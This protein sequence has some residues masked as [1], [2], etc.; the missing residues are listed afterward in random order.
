MKLRKDIDEMLKDPDRHDWDW[1]S[2]NCDLTKEQIDKAKDHLSWYW[3]TLH[4]SFSEEE[5]RK[6]L[7][8][9]EW[10]WITFRGDITESFL[11]EIADYIPQWKALDNLT[12]S[13][14]FKREINSE[15]NPVID[16]TNILRVDR[17]LCNL[18]YDEMSEFISKKDWDYISEKVWLSTDSIKRCSKYINW[19]L[20]SQHIEFPYDFYWEFRKK[21]DWTEV[22]K[23]FAPKW[24][25]WAL[26]RFAKYIDWEQ[27]KGWDWKKWS[28]PFK[29][30]FWKRLGLSKPF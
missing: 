8:Y 17:H 20:L 9:I 27:V 19:F 6:Y 15:S 24:K 2:M 7:D 14:D 5:I 23:N 18:S 16:A 1:I 29:K 22:T 10:P 28:K 13:K 3:I 4:N 26:T 21:F 25:E 12:F 30:K 11:R